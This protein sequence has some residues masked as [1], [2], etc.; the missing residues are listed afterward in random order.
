MDGRSRYKKIENVRLRIKEISPLHL[1]R[2]KHII[3]IEIGSSEKVVSEVVNQMV[4]L[5]I[6]K[7]IEPMVYKVLKKDW[8]A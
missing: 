6:I 8:L 3:S 5:S 4:S 7:E 2:L 1:E